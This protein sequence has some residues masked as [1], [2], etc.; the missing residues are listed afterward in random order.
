MLP[1]GRVDPAGVT[2]PIGDGVGAV[3]A[4]GVFRAARLAAAL[5]VNAEQV[6]VNVVIGV[7]QVSQGDSDTA[8]GRCRYGVGAGHGQRITR[9]DH[10]PDAPEQA[11]VNLPTAAGNGQNSIQPIGDGGSGY[12]VAEFLKAN[13]VGVQGRQNAIEGGVPARRLNE[14]PVMVVAHDTDIERVILRIITGKWVKAQRRP[15]GPTGQR[16]KQQVFCTG[17]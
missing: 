3:L 7:G 6:N 5:Q 17:P 16:E 10:R 12:R 8:S 4:A 2:Q 14:F 13:D 1:E 15:A 9:G 11:K